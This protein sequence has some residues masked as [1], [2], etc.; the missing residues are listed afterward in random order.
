MLNFEKHSNPSFDA[1]VRI[2]IDLKN[3]Q[4]TAMHRASV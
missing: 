1:L 2:L 4:L 3:Q